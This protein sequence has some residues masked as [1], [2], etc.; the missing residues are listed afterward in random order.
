MGACSTDFCVGGAA[1]SQVSICNVTEGAESGSE[2]AEDEREGTEGTTNSCVFLVRT[3]TTFRLHVMQ[4]RN[5]SDAWDAQ[6]DLTARVNNSQ[7]NRSD[8]PPVLHYRP[9]YYSFNLIVTYHVKSFCLFKTI[10]H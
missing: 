9:A 6:S 7:S 10:L 5:W 2:T 4:R 8:S 3:T 1:S